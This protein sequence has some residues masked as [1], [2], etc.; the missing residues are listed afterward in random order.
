MVKRQV[1]FYFTEI[2]AD[3]LTDSSRVSGG[4][5]FYTMPKRRQCQRLYLIAQYRSH[6]N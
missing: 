1:L 2:P 6:L 4:G 3:I 5:W